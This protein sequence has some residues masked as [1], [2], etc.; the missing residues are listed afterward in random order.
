M[1]RR[2]P[3]T[4]LLAA[5]A[6]LAAAGLRAAPLPENDGHVHEGVASCASTV[7]HGRVN[8]AED[9][10]VW[11]NEYR[12][13]LRQDYHSRAYRTLLTE[14]SKDIAQKLGLSAAHTADLC[15][16][17][18]ADN[19]PV[20]RRGE[21]FQLDDGVGCEA[22]HGG[23][24]RWLESHAELGT[25]HS[26][27]V[28]RGLYPTDEPLAKAEL[29]LSCH[30]GTRDKLATHRIMGAGHPRL[31]FEL[32]TFTVNQPAHFTVDDDYRERKR[33]R[34]PVSSWLTGLA[35][36]GATL[37][38]LLASE[39]YGGTGPFPEL[40]FYQCHACH[41]G[42][43]ELRW[44]RDPLAPALD[45]GSVRLNDGPLRVLL[46]CLTATDADS[47]AALEAALRRIHRESLEGEG[48]VARQSRELATAL[49]RLAGR[50]PASTYSETDLRRLRS[51][52][53]EDGAGG[54]FRDYTAAEQAFLGIETLTIELGD[55][56]RLKSRLD[57][58]FDALGDESH[59]AP[60]Q[61]AVRSRQFLEA[62]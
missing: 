7:C 60:G 61:F 58:L 50:F 17:C 38:D 57:A 49:R 51:T 12:V 13:W 2:K 25:S 37:F 33:D 27:N 10:T 48:A 46:S 55:E 18:H 44:Q 40:A 31:T 34:E 36:N 29:C 47:A 52:L 1:V 54:H 41:H 39:A 43:D 11:L 9:A 5:A 42:M 16:D 26:D 4:G 23:S 14:Q 3:L 6:L 22:C 21:R 59:Y 19:V 24:E 45:P 56:E 30:L 32:E 28:S 8:R 35:I 15:L 20:E 62:L 53:L